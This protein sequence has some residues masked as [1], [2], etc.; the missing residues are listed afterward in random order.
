MRLAVKQETLACDAFTQRARFLSRT[1]T[2]MIAK[3][4]DK[5]EAFEIEFR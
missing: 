4:D 3:S 2:G 1:L 5:F